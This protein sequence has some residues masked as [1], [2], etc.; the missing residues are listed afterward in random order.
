VGVVEVGEV[1]GAGGDGVAGDVG[2]RNVTCIDR[3]PSRR[4]QRQQRRLRPL[5]SERNLVIAMA[6]YVLKVPVHALRGLRR[7]FSPDLPSSMSHVYLTSWA[8]N[9]RPSCHLTPWRR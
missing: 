3:R 7:S 1:G 5:Q 9:G 6:G 2:R 8:V 4:Q